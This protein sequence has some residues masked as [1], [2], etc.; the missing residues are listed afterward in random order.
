M[1]ILVQRAHIIAIKFGEQLLLVLTL[2]SL[3]HV[4]SHI[5]TLPKVIHFKRPTD[6][7]HG[8]ID[9]T[10]Q[11]DPSLLALVHSHAHF[12][13]EIGVK[14]ASSARALHVATCLLNRG[15]KLLDL[16]HDRFLDL[17]IIDHIFV[18]ICAPSAEEVN[19]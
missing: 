6:S 13:L 17:A 19:Q 12:L 5:V 15:R 9:V 4:L 10:I 8:L 1:R 2:I 11:A 14:S 18:V 16:A 7:L 3:W